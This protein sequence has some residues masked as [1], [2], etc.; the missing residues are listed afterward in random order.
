MLNQRHRLRFIIILICV[1]PASFLTTVP[2]HAQT[3]TPTPSARDALVRDI[4]NFADRHAQAGT[5]MQ[6]ELVVSIFEN[7]SVG[8]SRLEIADIYEQ[9]YIAQARLQNPSLWDQ[10]LPYLGWISTALVIAA[11]AFHNY[12]T[13]RV[14][15]FFEWLEQSIARHFAGTRLFRRLVLR[16]YRKSLQVRYEFLKIPFGPGQ[17]IH[18]EDI[19]IPVKWLDPKKDEATEVS[20]ILKMKRRIMVLGEPGSGKSMLLRHIMYLYANHGQDGLYDPPVPV[21]LELHRTSDPTLSIYAQLVAEL[22]RNRYRHAESF[23]RQNMKQGTLLLLFDGLDEIN[24]DERSRVVRQIIDLLIENSNCQVAITCRTAAYKNDFHD[25]VEQTLEIAP[26]TDEQISRFLKPWDKLMPDH[27]SAEELLSTLHDQ[28]RIMKLA[29]NPLLLTIISYIYTDTNYEL[30]N[31]RA[32]FYA[33]V[34]DILLRQWHQELHQNKFDAPIKYQVL[35]HLG[36]FYQDRNA[37]SF[38]DKRTVEYK[39]VMDQVQLAI[40]NLNVEKD[41]KSSDIVEEI[42]QRSGLLLSLDGG[43][44]FEFAHSTL[45]EFFAAEAL[46]DDQPAI[47]DRFANDPQNWSETVKLWCGLDHDS[48]S[49]IETVFT[50]D[51]IVAFECLGD[52]KVVDSVVAER[53]VNYFKPQL[54]IAAEDLS[55]IERAFG[56]VATDQRARGQEVFVFLTRT[57]AASS[58]P[59]IRASAAR[60]L[61]L[62]NRRKAA[63]QLAQLHENIIEVRDPLVQMGEMAVAALITYG[64][65]GSV[66]TFAA[67]EKIGTRRALEYIISLLWAG[68]A[69]ASTLQAK[70]ALY[71]SGSLA[72]LWNPNEFKQE[73]G[74]FAVMKSWKLTSEQLQSDRLDWLIDPFLFGESSLSSVRLIAGRIAYLI[75]TCT[76]AIIDD[77]LGSTVDPHLVIAIMVA[78]L[79]AEPNF[80]QSSLNVVLDSC[81][82][83]IERVLSDVPFAGSVFSF[84]WRTTSWGKTP[85][86]GPTGKQ[87]NNQLVRMLESLRSIEDQPLDDQIQLLFR[88]SAIMGYRNAHEEWFRAQH[89]FISIMVDFLKLSK[90]RQKLLSTLSIQAQVIMIHLMI[91]TS[92]SSRERITAAEWKELH[93][94]SETIKESEASGQSLEG[95]RGL[96]VIATIATVTVFT[97]ATLVD[98]INRSLDMLE[99]LIYSTSLGLYLL[100][101]LV[102]VVLA[103]TAIIISIFSNKEEDEYAFLVLF[104]WPVFVVTLPDFASPLLGK[105][106][107]LPRFLYRGTKDPHFEPE[108]TKTDSLFSLIGSGLYLSFSLISVLSMFDLVASN[109]AWLLALNILAML[110]GA[111]F[112][113]WRFSHRPIPNPNPDT[114]SKYYSKSYLEAIIAAAIEQPTKAEYHSW[115]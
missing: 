22:K 76:E 5:P 89:Q 6:T 92:R 72:P 26:F 16:N 62:T 37:Q 67:L 81:A 88:L 9:E 45:R 69:T 61:S 114:F 96:A 100:P 42:V 115:V 4:R 46:K 99:K 97:I 18:M 111:P 98:H 102:P 112:L 32:E 28:P 56:S 30:P 21:L 65:E 25:V 34:S 8:L 40:T 3:S 84:G 52:A 24:Q 105:L 90:V 10:L 77:L 29:R 109:L 95:L 11:L 113:V 55:L 86:V 58:S 38:E 73:T 51:P 50:L 59:S 80:E 104:L 64:Q 83:L 49:L 15:A 110:L 91:L 101:M 94:R 39:T 43:Q 33:Q 47:L 53:I 36:L 75:S 78:Q 27:K 20:E 2:G 23:L 68:N 48:T 31:S 87:I 63:E 70:A 7:N 79:E 106:L 14:L 19:Y 35:A 60:A 44:R 66:H 17:R 108:P 82:N 57:L 54:G 13:Q 12:L 107:A 85:S 103:V 71:L 74:L 93:L 1:L 41:T